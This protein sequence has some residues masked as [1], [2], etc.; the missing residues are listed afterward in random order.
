MG[1]MVRDDDLVGGK[2]LGCG[3]GGS[4]SLHNI[5]GHITSSSLIKDY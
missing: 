1:Q 4:Q 3:L 2:A 5:E